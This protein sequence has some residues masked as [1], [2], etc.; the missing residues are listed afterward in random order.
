MS[1][2][3]HRIRRAS[4]APFFSKQK[5]LSLEPMIQR[6]IGKFCERIRLLKGTGNPLPL[7]LAYEALT[8]DIITEYCMAKSYGHLDQPY[9]DPKYHDMITKLGAVMY[10]SRLLPFLQPILELLPSWVVLKLDPGMGSWVEF[11][12]VNLS[13]PF[14][15]LLIH[16]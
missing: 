10:L 11:Q 9:W 16:M 1:H 13:R 2:D 12:E 3:L 14:H 5:I 7:R 8:T 4:V 6:N 15:H